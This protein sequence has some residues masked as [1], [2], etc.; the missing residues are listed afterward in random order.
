MQT[1]A[2][3]REPTVKHVSM[4]NLQ[5]KLVSK[6]TLTLQRQSSDCLFKNPVRTAL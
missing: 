4:K 1:A 3:S 2:H 5:T 6:L